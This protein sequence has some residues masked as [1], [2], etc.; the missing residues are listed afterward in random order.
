MF[1]SVSKQTQEPVH[2]GVFLTGISWS[3]WRLR[4]V[5][6]QI[7]SSR[8]ILPSSACIQ[9]VQQFIFSSFILFYGLW[10]RLPI[11]LCTTY[12]CNCCKTFIFSSWICFCNMT[13]ERPWYV[14]AIVFKDLYIKRRGISSVLKF[15]SLWLTLQKK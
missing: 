5:S 3:D 10:R 15:L 9:K 2:S 12:G 1:V 8:N 11:H 7:S 6:M 4:E 13:L 14:I